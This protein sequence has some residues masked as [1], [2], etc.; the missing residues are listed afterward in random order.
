ML[1]ETRKTSPHLPSLSIKGF[2]GIADL[3]I[4]HL[5]P[6]TLITGENNT[7]KT[8]ILEAVRLLAEN[9]SLEVIREILRLREED[10]AGLSDNRDSPG[11]VAFLISGLFHGFPPLSENLQ[12]I[13]LSSSDNSQQ[14]SIEVKWYLEKVTEDGTLRR[15]PVDFEDSED[16]DVIPAL[17]VT[18]KNKTNILPI[19]RIDRLTSN[20]RP[21]RAYDQSKT[22]SRFVNSILPERTETLSSLWDNIDL[23]ERE[24]DVLE[25][26]RIMDP[27]IA[28]VTML[29]DGSF[30]RS[31][32]AV[33]RSEEF[34]RRIPLRSFGD[35][36]NRLFCIILSLVN[37]AD[38]ILLIDEFEN[39]MH[40]SV[41][42][43][44]W[45]TVFYLAQK[46]NVQVLATTHSF[47][48]IAGFRQAAAQSEEIEGLLVRVERSG[49]QMRVVQYTEEDLQIAVRQRIEVR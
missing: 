43:E 12:P 48:C 13:V 20:R 31:R 32:T 21:N 45:R 35:G 40:Y 37:V 14:M 49:N 10:I 3:A 34:S 6:V 41:Q 9:A 23:T 4:P 22:F 15:I 25:A 39:G 26:L 29:G 1:A 8:S 16:G 17:A 27:N 44:A 24:Q 11:G 7:G 33:V 47:D 30:P 19:E 46:L 2:R 42:V 18:T 38:G 36:M 28:A 5:S